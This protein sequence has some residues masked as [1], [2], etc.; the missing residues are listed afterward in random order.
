[1]IPLPPKSEISSHL[2]W[3]H[4]PVHVRP[5]QNPEDRFSHDVAY[6]I[7]AHKIAGVDP[8]EAAQV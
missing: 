1:M 6:I 2:L 7:N 3:L 5:F 8:D 4:S